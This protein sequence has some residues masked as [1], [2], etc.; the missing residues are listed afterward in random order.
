MDRFSELIQ[1]GDVFARRY[2]SRTQVHVF[3]FNPNSSK[4]NYMRLDAGSKDSTWVNYRGD[5][6]RNGWIYVG[7]IPRSYLNELERN[8]TLR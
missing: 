6:E 4:R 7:T 5:Y 3:L 8:W 1:P 2:G